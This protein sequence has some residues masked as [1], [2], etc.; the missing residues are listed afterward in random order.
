[1]ARCSILLLFGFLLLLGC[2]KDSDYDNKQ[3]GQILIDTH[4]NNQDFAVGDTL[5][6]KGESI[7]IHKL[8]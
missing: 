8:Q 7:V 5:P 2:G 4:Y 3:L 1:M 6:F